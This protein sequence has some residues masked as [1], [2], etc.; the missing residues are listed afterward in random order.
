MI[1]LFPIETQSRELDYKL[2]LAHYCAAQ[3]GV[4]SFVGSVPAIH[5]NIE[6]FQNGLYFSKTIFSRP[7]DSGNERFYQKV[8]SLGFDIAYLH[9]EGGV[10][11]G[12]ERDWVQTL[13][14]MYDLSIFDENDLVM[15]WGEWQKDAEQKRNDK[16]IPLY[17]TGNPRFDL[18]KDYAFLY[19]DEVA[20]LREKYGDYVLI[21]GKY[22]IANHGENF[23]KAT[24]D[25][26]RWKGK[27]EENLKRFYGLTRMTANKMYAMVELTVH[28]ALN[29]PEINFIF[30]PHP[31]ERLETYKDLFSRIDNIIIVREGSANK[32]I[33]GAK[34]LIHDGCTTAL[35]AVNSDVSILNYTK[36]KSELDVFLPTQIGV[37]ADSL[38]SAVELFKDLLVKNNKQQYNIKDPLA[39]SLLHNLNHQSSFEAI[40]KLLDEYFLKEKKPSNTPS[41]TEIKKWYYKSVGKIKLSNLK[42][43][44]L[45][46]KDKVWRNKYLTNKFPGM[47]KNQIL[48]KIDILN[49]HANSNVKVDFINPN[50][51]RLEI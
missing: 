8:K 51:I 30:R 26:F 39:L 36:V 7:R 12:G 1:A 49:K 16:N 25:V 21:S 5:S 48:E 44:I 46:R 31:S 14:K 9:E 41:S 4:K 47:S 18:L 37:K 34:V 23:H 42:N 2:I 6:H 43:T 33:L 35:E 24:S 20:A 50:M 38:E 22:T 15:L 45:G 3:H 27:F 10:W 29:F 17:V 13:N 11:N 28:L 40:F 32:Y 19:E